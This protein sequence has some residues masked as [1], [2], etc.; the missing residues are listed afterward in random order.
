MASFISLRYNV[1]LMT[2]VLHPPQ[3]WWEENGSGNHLQ[4]G[5]GLCEGWGIIC[6]QPSSETA[7]FMNVWIIK[8]LNGDEKTISQESIIA[9]EKNKSAT[10]HHLSNQ[11]SV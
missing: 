11:L 2:L 7:D 6:L 1:E 4:I 10:N 5:S 8:K 9:F 3:H